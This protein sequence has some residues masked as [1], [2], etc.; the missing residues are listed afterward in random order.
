MRKFI[1]QDTPAFAA[2]VGLLLGVAIFAFF[3]R[4]LDSMAAQS[5]LGVVLIAAAYVAPF[6]LAWFLAR[7]TIRRNAAL[8]QTPEEKEDN[9]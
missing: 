3:Y 7:Y 8:R 1:G 5:R 6:A 9:N 2:I 4:E